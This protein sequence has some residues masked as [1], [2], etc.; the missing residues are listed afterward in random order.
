M[1][2]FLFLTLLSIVTMSFEG[3]QK[4]GQETVDTV[5]GCGLV[6]LEGTKVLGPVEVNGELEAQGAAM[7]SLRVNG[8]ASLNNCFILGTTS[9]DGDLDADNT[10]FTK[11]VSVSSQKI[12]LKNCGLSTLTVRNIPDYTGAQ[13]VDLRG[14]TSVSGPIVFESENGEIWISDDC[15]ISDVTGA[16]I[17]KK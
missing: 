6:V 2:K 8:H 4:H 14:G 17:S 1:K 9:I 11:G 5:Q 7:S 12:V 16:K 10:K 15:R 3:Y 13:I